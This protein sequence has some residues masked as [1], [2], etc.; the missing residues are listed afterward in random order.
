MKKK[1]SIVITTR[2]RYEMLKKCVES[3]LSSSFNDFELIIIDDNS[4]DL[5]KNT[6][7]SDFK[8]QAVRIYHSAQPLMMVKARNKG[9]EL[10]RGEY[11][12]FIDDDNKIEPRMIE[13]LVGFLDKNPEVGI[14]GP[15]MYYIDGTKYLDYQKIDFY[16]GK[17]TGVVSDASEEYYLSDGIP[18]VFIIKRKVVDDIGR[19]DVELIQTYTEPDYSFLA[20][21][22]GYTTVIYP[23]AI[24][25]HQL[26]I[27]DRYTSR[28]L[29]GKYT[30]KAYCLM[31][32]R[33]VVIAR[34]GRIYHKFI[35][36][37]FFSWVW[38]LMYTFLIVARERRFDLIP[39][40][41][42][43]WLDGIVYFF[44]GKLRRSIG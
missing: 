3:V 44:T 12:L 11:I 36:I 17:T 33:T 14:A 18:N 2:N 34:Y 37:I 24:T 20:K 26:E 27:R 31:R 23:K 29:G 40:Y 35:Y 32:N 9:I 30:Q 28:A 39:L 13:Y 16:T 25:F 19:F 42:K 6:R 5:T 8:H 43:G 38:P 22:H 41:W 7:A 15:S 21:L 10:S 1:L 4:T